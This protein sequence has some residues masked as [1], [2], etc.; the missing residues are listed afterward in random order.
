[1]LMSEPDYV[2]AQSHSM[3]LYQMYLLQAATLSVKSV[4]TVLTKNT[5]TIINY[6]A[7]E[8]KSTNANNSIKKEKKKMMNKRT[9]H[10]TRATGHIQVLEMTSRAVQTEKGG[11]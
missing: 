4:S 10:I 7:L 3:E 1:M 6:T 5:L 8:F 2:Y 9:T 11:V